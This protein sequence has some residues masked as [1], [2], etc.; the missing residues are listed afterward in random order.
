MDINIVTAEQILSVPLDRPEKLYQVETE[1]EIKSLYRKFSTLWHPDKHIKDGKDTAAVFSH[2]KLLYEKGLE[3]MKNGVWHYG[4]MLKLTSVDKKEFQIKY[5]MEYPF[6]LGVNYIGN[7]I[8]V[9]LIEL[10][11]EDLVKRAVKQIKSL[12]YANDKMKEE[13]AKYLPQIKSTFK[14]AEHI[15]LVMEKS[16]DILLLK[17][18]LDYHK[19]KI[20]ARHVAWILSGLYNIA[21]FFE[22][23]QLM[24]GGF[25]IDNYYINPMQHGGAL[26][27][28]WW[29]SHKT[30]EKLVALN[31]QAIDVAPAS[32][33]NTKKAQGS[34]DLEMIRKIGRQLLGDETGVYLK[35]DKDIPVPLINWLRDS[36]M[37][38]AFDEYNLWQKQVLKDSF[39]AR[40]FIEMKVS[41]N[42]IYQS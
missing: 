7:T 21:C 33:L 32:L 30:G 31:Q 24:H 27:G 38:N 22:Y 36:S 26:L 16:P 19:G 41:A 20:P 6:E 17:D 3:K 15:V 12:K 9:W 40:R 28:G 37:H 39:G 34:L 10:Q 35:K 2:L 11:Y 25:S 4:N 23:N 18:I 13:M 1:S 42:D 14:T 8:S 29:F 5:Y